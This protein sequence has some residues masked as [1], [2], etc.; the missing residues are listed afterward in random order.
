[1]QHMPGMQGARGRTGPPPPPPDGGALEVAADALGTDPDAV[2]S[3]LQDGKSLDDL[4]TDRRCCRTGCST[5]GRCD[6]TV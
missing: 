4:A 2:L 6:R 1:M 5:T 3:A